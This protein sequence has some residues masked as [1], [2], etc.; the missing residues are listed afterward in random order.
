MQIEPERAETRQDESGTHNPELGIGSSHAARRVTASDTLQNRMT[1]QA[2]SRSRGVEF[3]RRFYRW[4]QIQISEG[5]RDGVRRH[6]KTMV[7]P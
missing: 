5:T 3:V 1:R 2:L 7:P 6:T 4:P